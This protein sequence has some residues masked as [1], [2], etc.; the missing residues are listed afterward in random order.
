MKILLIVVAVALIFWFAPRFLERRFVYFPDRVVNHDPGEAGFGN[1]RDVHFETSD[2][3]RIHGW[4]IPDE[5]ARFSLIFCHGNAGNISHRLDRLKILHALG[6]QTLMFDYRGY[7]RSEGDP[8]ESGLYK[9]AEAA[10]EWVV[11]NTDTSKCPIVVYGESLGGVVALDL[12][13]KKERIRAVI[14]EGTFSSLKDIGKV[15]MPFIPSILTT[16]KLDA[17]SRIGK[18]GAPKLIL[19]SDNDE[20]IPFSMGQ[21][22]YE[23][24]REPK[25]FVVLNGSHNTA[26]LDAQAAYETALRVFLET[27]G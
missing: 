25:K 21:K 4:W 16:G 6:F 5:R 3:Q 12:A 15:H 11:K 10:Y 13:L 20:I 17:H 14:V 23:E 26:F 7:G 9:D 22:L 1:Y 19:H 27:L 2:H 8:I 18:I 24:A